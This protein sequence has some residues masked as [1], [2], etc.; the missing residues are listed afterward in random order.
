MSAGFRASLLAK[1][2]T[3]LVYPD[4]RIYGKPGFRAVG[5]K[6]FLFY[7]DRQI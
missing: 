1:V 4:G 3:L 7:N 5:V 2:E 6:P